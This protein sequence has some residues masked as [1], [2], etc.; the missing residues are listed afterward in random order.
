M[1]LEAFAQLANHPDFAANLKA[2]EAAAAAMRGQQTGQS[3]S[4]ERSD[5]DR[6]RHFEREQVREE[7]RQHE[8][9]L[10]LLQQL[11]LQ[12]QQQQQAAAQVV[13]VSSNQNGLAMS[14]LLPAVEEET[15]PYLAAIQQIQQSFAAGAPPSLVVPPTHIPLYPGYGQVPGGP[16]YIG[17]R[18]GSKYAQ[19][20]AVIEEMSSDLRPTYSGSKTSS[21]RF[22]RGIAQARILLRECLHET[23]P[24]ST[25]TTGKELNLNRI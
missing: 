8:Q 11:A 21:E 23:T 1:S 16:G 10:A 19:L 2:L 7:E 12:Q 5:R 25:A 24:S 15:P 22:K 4:K 13:P 20:L 18:G 17:G 3:S 9:Q 6:Q 14:N